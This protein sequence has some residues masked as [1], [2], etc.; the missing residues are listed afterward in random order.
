MKLEILT[1]FDRTA[2]R[3]GTPAFFVNTAVAERG[4]VSEVRNPAS[5]NPMYSS[6]NDFALFHIGTYDDETC[7][8]VVLDPPRLILNAS[9]VPVDPR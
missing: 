6:P 2:E 8:L 7:E 9:S 4:F 3:Y 1:V 5:S